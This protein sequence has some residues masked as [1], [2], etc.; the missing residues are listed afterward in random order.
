MSLNSMIACMLRRP[1][2]MP[3]QVPY[4]GETWCRK[5][6]EKHTDKVPVEV[7]KSS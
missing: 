5:D 1:S 6:V 7:Q 4:V 2:R 3:D